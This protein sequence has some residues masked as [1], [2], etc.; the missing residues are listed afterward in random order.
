[1]E[2]LACRALPENSKGIEMTFV[3]FHICLL[4]L[5]SQ[6]VFIDKGRVTS[7][8]GLQLFWIGFIYSSIHL[9]THPGY[10]HSLRCAS[11][12][13]ILGTRDREIRCEEQ[14]CRQPAECMVIAVTGVCIKPVGAALSLPWGVKE[15]VCVSKRREH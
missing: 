3:P 6:L 15:G 1:M 7:I 9:Y 8:N 13:P 5:I 14:T 2:Y 11:Q 10:I 12:F 4:E